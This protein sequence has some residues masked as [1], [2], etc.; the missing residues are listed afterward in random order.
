MA[1]LKVAPAG[2]KSYARPIIPE[3][4]GNDGGVVMC[5][6]LIEDSGAPP[7]VR[8]ARINFINA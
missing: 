1:G 4:A 5:I 6:M 2:V 8:P 3:P 7:E